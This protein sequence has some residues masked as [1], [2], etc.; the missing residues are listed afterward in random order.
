MKQ[1]RVGTFSLGILLVIIGMLILFGGIKG[2][3][4]ALLILKFWPIILISIGI[5]ILYFVYRNKGAEIKLKYDVLAVFIFIILVLI[6]SGVFVFNEFMDDEVSNVVMGDIKSKAHSDIMIKEYEYD[7]ADINKIVIE[8][9][10]NINIKQ[11]T[12]NKVRIKTSVV[13]KANSKKVAEEYKEN[14]IDIKVIDG[15]LLISDFNQQSLNKLVEI[16][17]IDTN[18]ELFIPE[19]IDVDINNINGSI[20]ISGIKNKLDI[21]IRGS[22]LKGNEI[23]GDIN[24]REGNGYRY[25]NINLDNITGDIQLD[26]YGDQITL[27]NINGSLSG[28][29]QSDRMHVDEL[30]GKCELSLNNCNFNIKYKEKIQQDIN[31]DGQGSSVEIYIPKNQEGNYYLESDNYINLESKKV[32]K[33]DDIKVVEGDGSKVIEKKIGEGP[34]IK[35][36]LNGGN[37]RIK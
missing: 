30:K 35:I 23:T 7:K 26:T 31:I 6:S 16:G 21:Y 33:E 5:E 13:V 15:K 18:Y 3:S 37:F 12:D 32:F 2:I 17:E 36:N 28:K 22:V 27:N 14:V 25:S 1:M 4:G 10:G 34:E 24:I 19:H 29:V 20:N 11:S 9:R 8:D